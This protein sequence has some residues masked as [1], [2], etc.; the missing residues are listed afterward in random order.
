M[1]LRSP[2]GIPLAVPPLFYW[3]R[4][5]ED[6]LRI[7]TAKSFHPHHA[8]T[9]LCLEL[10]AEALG[11]RPPARLLDVGCGSG[12]IALAAAFLGVDSVVG[13]DISARAIAESLANARLNGLTEKTLW[14][15]GSVEA[16]R[17]CFPAVVA[18][19][20]TDV[21][22]NLVEDLVRLTSTSGG[23]LIV[24]GFHDIEWPLLE[25]RFLAMG[26]RTVRVLSRD[27]SFFGVPPSGSF[28]WWAARLQYGA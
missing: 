25:G 7:R 10:L 28:T 21:M 11:S 15:V 12:V 16:V 2:K 18:N 14:I 4:H 3:E 22:V 20:R 8:T 6:L 5:R 19:L 13:I 24:S 9:L 1:R 23:N 27:Q 17:G 26:L